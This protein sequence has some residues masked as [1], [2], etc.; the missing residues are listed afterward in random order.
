MIGLNKSALTTPTF[1]VSKSLDFG[2]IIK[3]LLV[4]T[5]WGCPIQP[6]P[7]PQE[8]G[9]VTPSSLNFQFSTIV[10]E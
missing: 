7:V 6:S 2:K 3:K 5:L 10:T 8:A 9:E 4:A 1:S